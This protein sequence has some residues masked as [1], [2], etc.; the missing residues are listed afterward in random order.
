[1]KLEYKL[2]ICLIVSIWICTLVLVYDIRQHKSLAKLEQDRKE[3]RKKHAEY[4][5]NDAVLAMKENGQEVVWAEEER[6][7]ENKRQERV[8]A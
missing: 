6:T 5:N 8:A 3:C 7:T 4:C 1:M 2:V